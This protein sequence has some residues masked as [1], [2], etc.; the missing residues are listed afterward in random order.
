MRG[1]VAW[2]ALVA[3]GVSGCGGSSSPTRPQ[4]LPQT[5]TGLSS[6]ATLTVLSGANG[7]PVAGAALTIGGQALTTNG[8][9]QARV[10]AAAPVGTLIDVTHPS[11]LDRQTSV[12]SGTGEYITLWPRTTPEGLD[13]NYTA[14]LVY[15]R[16]F[17]SQ[18]TVGASPLLRLPPAT[19]TIVLTPSAGIWADPAAMEA[20]EAAARDATNA[21]GG[22]VRVLFAGTSAPIGGSVVVTTR[23]APADSFCVA[24]GALAYTAGFGGD[25][26]LVKGDIV[27]CD[28]SIARNTIV[29]LHELGHAF[30]LGHAP[31]GTNDIMEPTLV[32]RRA[33]TFGPRETLALRMMLERPPGN[34]FPDSDRGLSASSARAEHIIVCH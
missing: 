20:H 33:T 32:P 27:F 26:M 17:E 1:R 6:G 18:Q 24:T 5:P 30:G 13:E 10:P 9:G 2:A 12:R 3:A 22:R 29:V 15:S 7:A 23:V 34:R 28:A 16:T 14:T 21:T 4:A 19:D 25:F 31:V 11:H 8:A